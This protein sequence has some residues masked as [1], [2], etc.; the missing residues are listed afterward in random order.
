[1]AV[2]F[3]LGKT[4][5]SAGRSTPGSAPRTI[6]A[7]AMA[8]PVLPAVMNPAAWPSRTRRNPTRMEESR[9]ERTAVAAFSCIPMTSV[10][11]TTSMGRFAALG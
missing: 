8:A 9:L 7:V 4:A 2:P 6:L 11:F 3:A 10:A 1:M 5:A